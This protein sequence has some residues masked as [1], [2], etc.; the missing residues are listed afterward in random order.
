MIH[1]C[2]TS[3][4]SATKFKTLLEEFYGDSPERR[5]AA[6]YGLTLTA[7]KPTSDMEQD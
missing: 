1:Q 3:D 2:Q 6:Q 5:K 4:A 7:K